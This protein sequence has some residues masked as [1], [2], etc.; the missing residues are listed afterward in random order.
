[1]SDAI[2]LVDFENV[3]KLDLA[4][5]PAHVD[6]RIFVGASQA[7][8][9][10]PL[11]MQAQSLGARLEWIRIDGQGSNALDF[12]IAFYLGEYLAA[13]HSA[14]YVILSRDKGF[15]PLVRHLKA[16]GLDVA[17]VSALADAFPGGPA[18]RSVRGAPASSA[19]RT[20]HAPPRAAQPAVPSDPNVA[21]A[22]A[23]L[24]KADKARRPRTRARLVAQVASYF[25]KRL[26]AADVETLVGRL[27]ADG[28]ISESNGRLSYHF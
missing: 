20:S 10:M 19:T 17:R 25:P 24:A 13:A 5:I 15:D 14:R 7:K 9:P 6:V 16:R 2:L 27:F 1:M 12:H 11:V 23:L 8:V 3:Q 4:L 26:A 28:S 22:L 18:A 21:R